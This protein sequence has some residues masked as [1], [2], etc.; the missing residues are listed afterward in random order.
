MHGRNVGDLLV[1]VEPG[2]PLVI[3]H[4]RLVPVLADGPKDENMQRIVDHAREELDRDYGKDWLSEVVGRSEVPLENAYYKDEP[5]VWSRF[6]ADA[7]REAGDA[8]AAVD[9]TQFEGFDQPAGPITREQLFVLYPRIFE[10]EKHFGWTVWTTNIQGWIL[11]LALTEAFSQGLPI[12]ASGITYDL[13]SQGKATH[14]KING[15]SFVSS[16][17]YKIA[18]PEGIIRGAFGLSKYLHIILKNSHDTGIPMWA[19]TEAKLKRVGVI[20]AV[21]SEP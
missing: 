2:K 3:L 16:R 17:S 7:I 20:K 5:T 13:D 11:K 18:A 10:F 9:A 1:D 19:A 12:Q 8:E 14:F 15:E 6:V 4:Y 21:I